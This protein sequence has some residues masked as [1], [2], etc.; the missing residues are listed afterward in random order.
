MA[1]RFCPKIKKYD[2]LWI[3]VVCVAMWAVNAYQNQ[4][5]EKHQQAEIEAF[6]VLQKKCLFGDKE[7]CERV[8][9]K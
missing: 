1:C 2:I 7:A 6:K 4:K 5:I 8:Y 9:S 3:V